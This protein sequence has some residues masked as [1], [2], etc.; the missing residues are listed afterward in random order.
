MLVAWKESGA[1]AES[2]HHLSFSKGPNMLLVLRFRGSACP[3]LPTRKPSK[4]RTGQK[5][6]HNLTASFNSP[7]AAGGVPRG[8]P[9]AVPLVC[10][11]FQRPESL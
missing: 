10:C 6:L 11:E 7:S 4:S 1:G 5:A 2:Q 3:P 9:C 8:L